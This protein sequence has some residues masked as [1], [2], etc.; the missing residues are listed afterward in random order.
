MAL[1]YLAEQDEPVKRRVA[2]KILKPGMDSKQV[3]ARFESERQALAVLDHPNIAKIFDGGISESG[4]SYFAM[5]HVKG[6]PITDYCDDQRLSTEARIKLFIKVCAA[7]QHAHLK[8]L[9]HRDLKPSNILVEIIDGNPQPKIIDFGIAKATTT[10]LTEATLYTKIG[11]IVGTPQYMSP[12]QAGV[13]ALDIDTRTDIYSLGVVLY[14]L[15]V[16]ALPLE[17]GGIGDHAL[18]VTLRDRDPLKPSSRYTQLG[19]TQDE[20]AKARRT[21]AQ[22]LTR[23]LTG[24]LDWIAMKAIEKDRT[25]RYETANALSMDCRRYLAHEPVL[26]RPPSA[27]YLFKR[28]VRRNRLGVAAG[29]IAVLA[30]LGGTAAAT[31]GYLRATEAELTALQALA[32]AEAQRERA[33][34]EATTTQ[35]ISE[36]LIGLFRATDPIEADDEIPTTLDI[37]DRGVERIHEELADEPEARAPLMRMLANVY[38]NLGR[39]DQARPLL[40][41]FLDYA[42][43][44][45]D[46]QNIAQANYELGELEYYAGNYQLAQDYLQTSLEYLDTQV[47]DEN[48]LGVVLAMQAHVMIALGESEK[49]EAHLLKAIAIAEARDDVAQLNTRLNLLGIWRYR[50]G[51]YVGAREMFETNLERSEEDF[52]SNHIYVADA[53]NNL[54]FIHQQL[55]NH[56]AAA[57]LLERALEITE[58]QYEVDTP[59]LAATLF[60]LARAKRQTEGAEAVVPLMER[61]VDIFRETSPKDYPA[62]LRMLAGLLLEVDQVERANALYAESVALNVEKLGNDHEATARSRIGLGR[63]FALLGNAA[64]AREQLT[65]GLDA[66]EQ[67]L[68][69]DHLMFAD[70]LTFAAKGFHEIGDASTAARLTEQAIGIYGTQLDESHARLL[71]ARAQLAEL[72][73]KER[74]GE[75]SPLP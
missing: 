20:I 50:R 11:Q 33:E 5:E 37:V 44:T 21:D 35:R 42:E 32:E 30:V 19:D 29:S 22:H 49:A 1:V 48:L 47:N 15:L 62:G 69:S 68:G 28:F 7:V 75:L 14:E 63:S 66:L 40:T 74:K 67:A 17:M 8:G 10:T 36:F 31:L 13:T 39:G 59:K 9:I 34:R 38:V 71:A 25:R 64:Q 18:Q 26:A 6:L 56:A 53:A 3:I 4:R 61:A 45:G 58:S 2:I 51:D 24:D 41:G 43:E 12:E 16:G 70:E 72:K 54:A 60:N 65:V 23:Q 57:G 73:S 27:G 52:G 46:P 55:D